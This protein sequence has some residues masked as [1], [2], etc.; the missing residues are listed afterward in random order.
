MEGLLAMLAMASSS[1]EGRPSSGVVVVERRAAHPS[2]DAVHADTAFDSDVNAA[3]V[4]VCEPLG[5]L[6]RVA[7]S[8]PVDGSARLA[9][10]DAA[11]RTPGA[12]PLTSVLLTPALLT[13]CASA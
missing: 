2:A 5:A 8:R 7:P 3:I 4:D 6:R 9:A 12:A 10:I 13:N 1:V 11:L